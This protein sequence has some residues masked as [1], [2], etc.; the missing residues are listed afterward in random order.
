MARSTDLKVLLCCQNHSNF[1]AENVLSG[2]VSLPIYDIQI[3]LFRK[4]K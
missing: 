2:L 3:H 4:Y 1:T